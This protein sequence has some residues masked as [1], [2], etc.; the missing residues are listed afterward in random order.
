MPNVREVA[1]GMQQNA[2]HLSYAPAPKQVV[3]FQDDSARKT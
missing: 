3:L 2:T 1:D